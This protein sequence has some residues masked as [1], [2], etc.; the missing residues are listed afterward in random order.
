LSAE[1][2]IPGIIRYGH[3]D[4]TTDFTY[5]ADGMTEPRDPSWECPESTANFNWGEADYGTIYFSAK[6]SIYRLKTKTRGFVP[7]AK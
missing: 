7:G 5:G 1:D 4:H 6:T 3:G 2:G